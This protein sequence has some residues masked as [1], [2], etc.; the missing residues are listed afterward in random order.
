MNGASKY[1]EYQSMGTV[2]KVMIW[3]ELSDS[4]WLSLQADILKQSQQFDQ[5]Y[6]R[7]IPDSLVSKLAN[8]QGKVRVPRDLVNMLRIYCDFHELSG[9]RVTPLVGSTLSD[10]GYDSEYSLRPSAHVRPV[11]SLARTLSIVDDETIDLAEPVL[12]D[13]GCLGK[14]YFVD[15][16]YKYLADIGVREYLVDGSGDARYSLAQGAVD[17]GLE[18]PGDSEKVIG[19]VPMSTGSMASSGV[20]R[21]K[22]SE[23]HHMIDPFTLKPTSGLLASWVI[24][25][26]AVLADVLATALFFAPVESFAKYEFEYCLVNDQLQIK[27]SA[28]WPGEIF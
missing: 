11:P 28:N 16:L 22:W 3:G 24:A 5:T 23:Y 10:L 20:N 8:T 18:H 27:K 19:V 7:F 6:S 4:T 9:G 14:G 21:R 12:L 17:I 2:W 26:E 15:K 1:F 25:P 13:L